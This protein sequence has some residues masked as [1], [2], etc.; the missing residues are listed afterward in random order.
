[1]V[2]HGIPDDRPLQTGDIVNIDVSCFVDGFHGD[3]SRTFLV[4]ENGAIDYRDPGFELSA[5]P[6]VNPE[7]V[8]LLRV[9]EQCLTDSIAACGPGVPLAKIGDI[10]TD[11]CDR[12]GYEVNRT[13]VVSE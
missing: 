9:S 12:H 13:F 3:T 7:A 2:C 1:V 4:G 6:A 10:V 11:I 8:R 5:H